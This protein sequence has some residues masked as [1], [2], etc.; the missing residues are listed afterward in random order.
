MVPR[1]SLART[2]RRVLAPQCSKRPGHCRTLASAKSSSYNYETGEANGIKF[3]SRDLPGPTTQLALVARA[4]TRFQLYPGFAEGLEK[5]AFKVSL[6]IPNF[7]LSVDVLIVDAIRLVDIQAIFFTDHKRSGTPG[8]RVICVPFEREPCHW[9]EVPSGRSTILHR[10][11]WRGCLKDQIHSSVCQYS[12][13]GS[14]A[15][16]MKVMS[17]TRR[18]SVSS[19][20]ARSRS[21]AT[22]VKWR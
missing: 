1:A 13:P 11:A 8:R 20:L 4:G 10:V 17:C 3:A 15:N 12:A 22:L 21:S 14:S 18:S 2:T 9:G 5:F 6:I 16:A 7:V 19:S